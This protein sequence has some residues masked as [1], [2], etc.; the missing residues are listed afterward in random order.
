MANNVIFVYRMFMDT[1]EDEKTKLISC[2]GAFRQFWGGLSQVSTA[3]LIYSAD[4]F[5]RPPFF[6]YI[7]FDVAT[8]VFQERER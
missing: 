6:F 7:Y 2:L 3:F 8:E 1:P 4:D 5:W